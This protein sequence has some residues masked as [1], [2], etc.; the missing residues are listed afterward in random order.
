M[1]LPM[2]PK[3][4]PFICFG[5]FYNLQP[6]HNEHTHTHTHTHT[7]Q[8]TYNLFL[9]VQCPLF[10]CVCVCACGFLPIPYKKRCIDV[11]YFVC[12]AH[13]GPSRGAN[14]AVH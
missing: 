11:V 13:Y 3:A 7:Q 10:V 5:V 14:E 9:F 6:T 12:R 4:A 2:K 8:H 1:A